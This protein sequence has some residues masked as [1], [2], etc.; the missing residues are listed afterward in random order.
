M[1]FICIKYYPPP[2]KKRKLEKLT[3][4][5]KTE[6]KQIVLVGDVSFQGKCP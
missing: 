1:E 5:V 3:G 4:E 6:E 2:P